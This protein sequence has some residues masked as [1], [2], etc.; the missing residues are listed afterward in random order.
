MINLHAFCAWEKRDRLEYPFEP[1]G[2]VP[3]VREGVIDPIEVKDGSIEVPKEPGL[4]IR[5]VPKLMKKHAT[6]F[7]AASPVRV[8]I[9]A[10]LE[11]G[12]KTALEIGKK[13]KSLPK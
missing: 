13:K 12:L 7:Y 3:A 8:A 1:P 10:I 2:W 9:E 6:L 11:K 5:L 4:G